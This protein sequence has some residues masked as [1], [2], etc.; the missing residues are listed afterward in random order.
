VGSRCRGRWAVVW[1]GMQAGRQCAGG[2]AGGGQVQG[3]VWGSHGRIKGVAGGNRVA[4]WGR[5][6]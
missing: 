6:G 2:M 4:E 1:A 3:S 5:W